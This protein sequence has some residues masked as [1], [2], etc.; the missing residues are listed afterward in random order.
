MQVLQNLG[1]YI[2]RE[3]VKMYTVKESLD[4]EAGVDIG[5]GY[6]KLFWVSV[7]GIGYPIP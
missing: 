6:R 5:I 3:P 1:S 7:T 4:F 2:E